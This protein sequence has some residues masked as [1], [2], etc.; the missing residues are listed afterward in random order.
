MPD[1]ERPA[2]F[3]VMTTELLWTDPHVSEQ[4]LRYHLDPADDRSSRRATTIDAAIDWTTRRFKLGPG[5]SVLDLGCGPGLYTSR[6]AATGADVTG[7]DFS[8]RSIA[9]ARGVAARDGTRV[10]YLEAD[11]LTLEL[12]DTFDLVTL[13]YCDFSALSPS[14]RTRLLRSVRSWLAPGGTFLF[15]VHTSPYLKT[16][17]EGT[18]REEHPDGSFWSATAHTVLAETLLYPA[19]GVSLDRYEISEPGRTWTIWNWLQAYD[20]GSITRVLAE[21][22][23]SVD[24]VLGDVTGAGYDPDAPELAILASRA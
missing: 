13:I 17:E 23:I 21:E 15:D 8:P 16:R 5:R 10:R 7:I 9:H 2:P 18:R 24:E 4:M 22:G 6:W 19:V 3:S 11:Y 12:E 1:A 20:P 14:Q